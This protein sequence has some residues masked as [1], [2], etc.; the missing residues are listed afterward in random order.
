MDQ[1]KILSSAL[2]QSGATVNLIAAE[3]FL[4]KNS[5]KVASRGRCL[6]GKQSLELSMASTTL[7]AT[8]VYYGRL[9]TD[10]EKIKTVN[11]PL[12]G[13]FAELDNG[14]P[15]ASVNAFQASLDTEGK[16]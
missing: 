1:A 6:G 8:V 15:P 3:S 16:T 10:I 9:P 12:L 4:R 11:E 14:I 2:D 5:T 7:D 13:I